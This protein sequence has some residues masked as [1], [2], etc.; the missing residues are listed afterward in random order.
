MGFE[1]DAGTIALWVASMVFAGIVGGLIAGLL[2]VGGGI[3]IV[4][5][6]Y[7]VLAGFGVEEGL[8]MKVAVATSLATI[9]ATSSVSVMS[10]HRRGAIDLSL[11]KSWS[12]PIFIG[13][14]AGTAF[15]GTVDGRVLTGVFATVALLVAINMLLR[16]EGV[17]VADGFPNRFAKISSGFFVGGVSAMMGI[18]GGTLSVPILTT[19]GFDI[20]RAVGT[21]AAI[22]FV[23][24]IP[25]TLGYI[26][27]GLG[28]EGRPPFSLGYFNAAAALALVPL[29]MLMAPVGARLA[30]SIPRRALQFC[31]AGFLLL[32]SARMFYDLYQSL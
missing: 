4:P 32:T 13:V 31:F 1:A 22:G 24:A 27:T 7:Q 9:I 10:H 28:A 2:G 20:R 19:Y 18:G 5:V 3:V 30:H 25:G 23:I 29:T 14:I 12:L 16:R 11:L 21:A 6:L 26:V 8:R 17:A 15:G